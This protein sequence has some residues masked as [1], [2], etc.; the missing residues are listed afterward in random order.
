MSKTKERGILV[1]AFVLFLGALVAGPM[2]LFAQPEGQE[3]E[4]FC[5]RRTLQ[6]GD[7]LNTNFLIVNVYNASKK[8]GQANRVR[9]NLERNG[10]LGGFVDNYPGELEPNN[11]MILTQNKEDPK[12]Q[13]LAKQFKGTVEYGQA[14]FETKDGLNI[15]VGPK[16]KGV[17]GKAPTSTEVKVPVQVCVPT[18][19]LPK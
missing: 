15:L 3:P 7:S 4:D 12:V 10:F 11:V 16:F 1:G 14:D 9:I 5:E 18:I 13:L 17:D 8:S 19:D 2:M 6:A